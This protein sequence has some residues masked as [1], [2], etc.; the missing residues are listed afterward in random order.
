MPVARTLSFHCRGHGFDPWSGNQSHKP[1]G[2]AKG[3]KNNR[4]K[5][6]KACSSR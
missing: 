1:S 2:V 5:N 6:R 3:K 4:K